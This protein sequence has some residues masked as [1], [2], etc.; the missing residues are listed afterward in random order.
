VTEARL[1]LRRLYTDT[2][3]FVRVFA[4]AEV[5]RFV[6]DGRPLDRTAAEAWVERQAASGDVQ[7]IERVDDGALV[8]WCG[9]VVGEDTGEPELLYGLD[10][11]H[12]GLGLAREAAA[13]ALAE[14]DRHGPRR[15]HATVDVAN[16]A[17][18]RIVES[19]GFVR[20]HDGPDVHGLPTA[21][22]VRDTPGGGR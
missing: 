5:M 6:G 18:I 14:A 7:A 11:L 17:S 12:W 22:F 19:L 1:R 15:L 3:W 10:Q 4:S 16:V 20:T 9:L 21:Y 13:L 2:A 8:G